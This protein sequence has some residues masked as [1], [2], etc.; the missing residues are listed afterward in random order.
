LK[1]LVRA[2]DTRTLFLA[3]GANYND[4]AFLVNAKLTHDAFPRRQTNLTYDSIS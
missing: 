4:A 1:Y 3:S 2:N